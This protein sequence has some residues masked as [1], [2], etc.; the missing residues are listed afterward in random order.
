[1]NRIDT[2]QHSTVFLV[3]SIVADLQRAI[4]ANG[5]DGFGSVWWVEAL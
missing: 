4:S 2:D 1:M 5:D 3:S